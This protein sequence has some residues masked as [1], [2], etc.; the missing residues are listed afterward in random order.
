MSAES[1][2]QKLYA[3]FESQIC[4]EVIQVVSAAKKTAQKIENREERASVIQGCK[5]IVDGYKDFNEAMRKGI[6]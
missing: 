2:K 5:G 4:E 6:I 3:G 1:P